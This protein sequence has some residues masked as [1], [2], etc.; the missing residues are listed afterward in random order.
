MWWW[1]IRS[2]SFR[3]YK[4]ARLSGGTDREEQDVTSL[5]WKTAIN[6]SPTTSRFSHIYIP[7]PPTPSSHA[8]FRANRC[9]AP[10]VG[11]K[12]DLHETFLSIHRHD[13]VFFL[14]KPERART[15]PPIC[16]DIDIGL[17]NSELS[18]GVPLLCISLFFARGEFFSFTEMV[19]TFPLKV[20]PFQP[21]IL[22][23]VTHP[24]ECSTLQAG[25]LTGEE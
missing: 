9:A 10:D 16:S 23:R 15:R 14:G 25:H 8:L 3:Y 12:R 17:R 19:Q 21:F 5:R 20:F 22:Q 24:L 7:N 2:T 13:T 6:H 18:Q 4:V 1:E 11:K